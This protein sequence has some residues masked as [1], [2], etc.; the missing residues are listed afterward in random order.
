MVDITERQ[1]PCAPRRQKLV[2]Q[3]GDGTMGLWDSETMG[4]WDDATSRPTKKSHCLVVSF[5]F[6]DYATMGRDSQPCGYTFFY[7]Q[8]EGDNHTKHNH[9]LISWVEKSIPTS[10]E[11]SWVMWVCLYCFR[12]R[13]P[14]CSRRSCSNTM[15]IY[16]HSRSRWVHKFF[17]SGRCC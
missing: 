8:G 12:S 16:K 3:S 10:R 14:Q 17:C 4:L 15:L 9:N 6:F 1:S 5:S 11:G 7:P 13:S 2:V